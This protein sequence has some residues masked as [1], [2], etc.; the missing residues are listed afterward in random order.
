VV[1]VW[2][3]ETFFPP[4]VW[5]D[6]DGLVAWDNM[7]ESGFKTVTGFIHQTPIFIRGGFIVPAIVSFQRESLILEY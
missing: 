3:R 5:Y 6:T 1:A 7:D 2:N 4:G